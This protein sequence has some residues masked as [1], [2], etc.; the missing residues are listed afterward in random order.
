M[1]FRSVRDGYEAPTPLTVVGAEAIQNTATANL[2]DTLNTMPVFAGSYTPVQG[3]GS[4]SSY[5]GGLNLLN[6][7]SM[8]PQRLLVLI[9]GQRTVSSRLDGVIDINNVPQQL[10]ARVDVVTAGASAVYGSDAVSGV[11]N[12]VLDKTY[13]GIK[14]EVSGGVT[15]YGDDRNWKIALTAG[16]PFANDR[17]HL[18]LSGELNYKDEVLTGAGRPWN[19]AGD[20]II[21]NPNYTATNGQ[22]ERLWLHD[23]GTWYAPGNVID[24]G[25][26][27]GIAFGV[28]GVP[29]NFNFGSLTGGIFSAGGD[30]QS[31]LWARF[32]KGLDPQAIRKNAFMRASYDV[33]DSVNLFVQTAWNESFDDNK[34]FATYQAG[35]GPTVLSGNPF[36]PASVQAQMTALKLTSI[37][38]GGMNQ[39]LPVIGSQSD[40][41][42]TRNVIGANGKFDAMYTPWTWNAY[43]QN[44]MTRINYNA[45]GVTR[46]S[47]RTQAID[48]VRAPNGAIVCRST[49][50]NPNDGCV[51]YNPMGIG[52]NSAATMNYLTS[53]TRAHVNQHLI[54]NVFAGSATGEPFSNW[55]G[56]ISLALSAEHRSE[57]AL[58]V[59]DAIT[60]LSD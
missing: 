4:P 6:L 19:Y 49:L 38:I 57:K 31:A 50:T 39:D 25:P 16:M 22:P 53:G 43:F 41:I 18:L 42:T 5:G 14:G 26:L 11:V 24:S 21:T 47:L 59:P 10:V 1:L 45:T 13:T 48:A 2:V 30:W 60:L 54:Q 37:H 20:G 55:A 34:G 51:P 29:Y 46:R 17:G 32:T 56:P 33:T 28:G 58:S 8:G 7:R 35:N 12:F 27:K 15:T 52:V 3:S 36:I 40:K 44:G 9:D 23:V